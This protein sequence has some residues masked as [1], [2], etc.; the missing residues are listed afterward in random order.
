MGEIIRTVCL[1]IQVMLQ[2]QFLSETMPG[3]VETVLPMDM[4]QLMAEVSTPRICTVN[5]R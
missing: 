4:I 1:Q 2:I 5:S 3:T